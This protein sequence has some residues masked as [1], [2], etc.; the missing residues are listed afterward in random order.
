MG[1]VGVLLAAAI[2]ILIEKKNIYGQWTKKEISLFF[3][4][5]LIGTSL[6]I[7]WVL[8]GDLYN[9]MELIVKIYRPITEPINSYIT[10]FK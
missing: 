5:L 2:S 8:L 7:V 3:I 1:V 10:Q 6:T 4:S 9:P